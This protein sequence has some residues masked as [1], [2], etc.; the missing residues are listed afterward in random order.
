MESWDASGLRPE[1]YSGRPNWT[2]VRVA[3]DSRRWNCRM[4]ASNLPRNL[5][6]LLSIVYAYF[7]HSY[8]YWKSRGIPHDEPSIPYGNIK[9]LGKTVNIGVFTRNLYNKYK[10]TGAKLCG[11]YFVNRP[12]AILLDLELIKNVLMRDFTNFDERGTQFLLIKFFIL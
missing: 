5:I 10:P 7:K 6:S 4:E 3:G 11:A 9:G 2:T 1:S 8:E 12:I